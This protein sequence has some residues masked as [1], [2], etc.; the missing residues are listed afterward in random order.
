MRHASMTIILFKSSSEKGKQINE[1]PDSQ[2][3]KG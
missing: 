2:L 1:H 3:R